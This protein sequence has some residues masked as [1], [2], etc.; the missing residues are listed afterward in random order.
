MSAPSPDR[1]AA[2]V[3]KAEIRE[4]IEYFFHCADVHDESLWE[5]CF[6]LDAIWNG[7]VGTPEETLFEGRDAIIGGLAGIGVH[8][9]SHHIV[10]NVAIELQ[11]DTHATSTTFIVANLRYGTRFFVRGTR[12][13]DKLVMGETGWQFAHRAHRVAWQYEVP[14]MIPPVIPPEVMAGQS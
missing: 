7:R 13:D 2:V 9:E 5:P 11:D 1:I 14:A 3:A 12:I 4:L 10:A 8:D 6:T